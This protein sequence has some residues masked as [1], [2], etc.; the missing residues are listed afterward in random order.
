M[1]QQ[2]LESA[3]EAPRDWALGSHSEVA[4]EESRVLDSATRTIPIAKFFVSSD[5]SD[6]EDDDFI[7]SSPNGELDY[8]MSDFNDA[9]PSIWVR[10]S[11]LPP[12]VSISA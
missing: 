12:F 5:G 11:M 7:I 1:S 6:D 3:D 4:R 2:G 8:L 9:S 10:M